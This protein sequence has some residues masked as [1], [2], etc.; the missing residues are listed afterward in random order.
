MR[1]S[2]RATASTAADTTSTAETADHHTAHEEPDRSPVAV[3]RRLLDATRRSGAADGATGTSGDGAA[4]TSGDGAADTSGDGA[5][6]TSADEAVIDGAGVDEALAELAALSSTAL[7]PVR[8]DRATALAFWLTLYNAGTQVLLAREPERYESRLRGVRFFGYEWLEID[9]EWL[10]LD[11][12]EHGILR[13]SQSKYGLGYLPR[14]PVVSV[15][16]FER[17]YRLASVDPRIHFA[18]NCGAASC[19]PIRYYDPGEI[20]TQL[21]LATAGYLDATVEY[22]PDAGVVTVPAPFRWYPGDFAD[23]VAFL[24]RYDAVPADAEPRLQYESWD[25]SRAPGKFASE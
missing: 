21:D 5:A 6:D 8:E 24:Q 7:A 15:D 17:R 12:I 13:G 11:D 19:P 16:A 1:E 4:D 25:W 9:G 18:L 3:A 2:E 20:D 10:S 14:L 23:P 22:D